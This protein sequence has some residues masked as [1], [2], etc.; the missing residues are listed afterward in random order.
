M[1]TLRGNPYSFASNNV[2]E[3]SLV[4]FITQSKTMNPTDYELNVK[5]NYITIQLYIGILVRVLDSYNYY[6]ESYIFND[7]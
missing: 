5:K 6:L 7:I 1:Y 2:V 4:E 3:I